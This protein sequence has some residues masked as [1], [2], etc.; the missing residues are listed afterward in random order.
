MQTGKRMVR[1]HE[2]KAR[3][4]TFQGFADAASRYGSTDTDYRGLLRLSLNLGEYEDRG[5]RGPIG[6]TEIWV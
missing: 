2:V 4:R 1:V 6:F 3:S 5:A